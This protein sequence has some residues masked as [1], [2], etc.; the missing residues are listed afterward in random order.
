MI[1]ND[2]APFFRTD[3]VEESNPAVA[4]TFASVEP[5]ETA[6]STEQN[7]EVRSIDSVTE[8]VVAGESELEAENGAQDESFSSDVPLSE[9]QNVQASLLSNDTNDDLDTGPDELTRISGIGPVLE[10]K[11]HGLGIVTFKQIAELDA[12][13]IA[14]I[15]EQLS[16]KGRIEREKWVEQAKTLIGQ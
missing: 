6:T 1:A 5:D 2:I 3:Y 12:E 16:F 7:E 14:I 9:S 11:L 8:Q 4:S 13:N 10:K 15:N